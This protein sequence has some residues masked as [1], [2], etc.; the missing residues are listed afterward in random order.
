MQVDKTLGSHRLGVYETL[1]D[2]EGQKVSK[3]GYNR[4]L[5]EKQLFPFNPFVQLQDTHQARMIEQNLSI[6]N[7][8]LTTHNNEINQQT[9]LG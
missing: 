8:K 9:E 7:T 1:R 2:N 5:S 6:A 3:Y 4:D